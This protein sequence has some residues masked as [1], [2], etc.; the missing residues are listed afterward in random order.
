MTLNLQTASAKS[1]CTDEIEYFPCIAPIPDEPVYHSILEKGIP[2]RLSAKLIQI[3][4]RRIFSEGIDKYCC[5]QARGT[6]GLASNKLR[7]GDIR[8]RIHLSSSKTGAA[9]FDHSF[10]GHRTFTAIFARSA[11]RNEYQ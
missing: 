10:S 3:L 11:A 5:K 6:N 9:A 1:K 7:R 8:T 2:C 4:P